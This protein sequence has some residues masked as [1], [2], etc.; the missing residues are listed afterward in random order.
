M[1]IAEALSYPR[2][3]PGEVTLDLR[4]TKNRRQMI[5]SI[6]IRQGRDADMIRGIDHIELIV[7]DVE[8]FVSFF[9]KL[10]FELIQRTK[11]HGDAAEAIETQPRAARRLADFLE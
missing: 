10:G 8:E 9:Q 11:H 1:L 7:R 6:K 5:G 4:P 2:G 3:M